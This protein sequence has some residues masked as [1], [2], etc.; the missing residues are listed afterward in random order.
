MHVRVP[1]ERLQGLLG[2]EAGLSGAE[3]DERRQR[4][5]R[6]DIVEAAQPT[7]W[8][9]ARDTLRDPMLWFLLGTA[10]L[11]AWLG[12][13]TEAVILLFALLPLLGMD[14]YLHRR[15]QASTQG[16][17]SR[18]ATSA[19]A[20]R[21]GRWVALPAHELVPGDLVELHAGEAVPADGLVQSCEQLLLDESML[22]GE[23]LPVAKQPFVA[24]AAAD[25]SRH[26]MAAGTRLL[27][28]TARV[29]IAYTGGDTV[30]GQIVRL[31]VQ[32]SHARTPLQLAIA[33]LVAT[34]LVAAVVICLLLAGIRLYQGHGIVDALLSAV[35][36]AV[37]ALPEEFPVV[38]T[39]FLGAGVYRLARRQAL[40]RRAVAVENIGRVTCICSDKT[41]TMTEGRLALV[42]REPASGLEED[43]LLA[44]A[45]LACRRDSGDPLDAAILALVP[46]ADTRT[47]PLRV[48]PFT[49]ARRRE[50]ALWPQAPQAA[51]AV[52]K[53]APET[54][55]DLC[56][57]AEAARA[58]W[59]ARVAAH[60]GKGHKV[61]A[62][63]SRTVDA[64]SAAGE[65]PS[66]G[67]VFAG[68][69][70]F[71]DPLREGVREA[72]RACMD[73]GLRV[74]MVTGDHPGTA[75][76]IALEAGLGGGDPVV[77][78]LQELGDGDQ[79]LARV[80]VV[81]RAAPAQKLD[82]V[83]RLQRQGEIV[84][85][86]GDGVNDAPALQAADIGIAMGGSGS[87]SSREVASIVLLDD[88][89][90]TIVG[91]IG[92]GRQLFRNLQASFAYLLMVHLPLVLSA[93]LVPISG[94]PLLYLPIH[95]VWLELLIH[96]TALLVFQDPPPAGHMAPV[97]RE[98]R[99]TFFGRRAWTVIVLT[100]LAATATVLLAYTHGAAQG[101]EYARTL[102]LATLV[103]ASATITAALS[104]LRSRIARLVTGASVA[105]LVLLVQV[106]ALADWVHLRP[107]G[108][109]DWALAVAGG[110]LGGSLAWLFAARGA[111]RGGRAVA[112][113]VERTG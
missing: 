35:T 25:A 90:R 92:E 91:A 71:A 16:L 107:L 17:A 97:V 54:V 38:F 87:Q 60:A 58:D 28:G 3:A 106:P 73:A 80:D 7:W 101:V 88:N 98:Q 24:G 49:E 13:R 36:L 44:L 19:R 75:R 21:D 74:I 94:Q 83:Q 41:G 33:R 78:T 112:M 82:L 85:V 20:L 65:E 18:L 69:L 95:I 63:A 67:F 6:N 76:A 22:S 93:A 47:A 50:T 32:G 51:L 55:L 108:L 27:G 42:R 84:A 72:V 26:W 9:L 105:S 109:L 57:L 43:A 15:T 53:G 48:F 79:P 102:A 5:G 14:A 64:A 39:F 100:G 113:P 23:S 12:D 46:Q 68:L 31:A 40:V 70:A 34:L 56:A 1:V 96:P 99:A 52:T 86:T 89:F 110:L 11:F 45:A 2:T 81:A 29:R 111:Q 103:L 10:A 66:H 4:H 37:A 77:A 62:F 61:I 8:M 104:G 30:Y 59:L